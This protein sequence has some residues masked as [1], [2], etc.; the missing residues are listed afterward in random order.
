MKV[1][2][3]YHIIFEELGLENWRVA[4]ISCQTIGKHP[5]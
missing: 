2:K 3:G 4:Y 1:I 5:S